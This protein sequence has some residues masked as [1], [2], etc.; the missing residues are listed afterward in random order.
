MLRLLQV[1]VAIR[2][3]R[4]STTGW[5]FGTFIYD[6]RVA[7]NDPYKKLR[8]VGVMWGNDPSLGPN[9][10]QHGARPKQTRLNP[11]TR[12][13]MQHYGWLG[14]LDGPVDNPK[15]SCLSCHSTA[16][17]G[18][19]APMVPPTGTPEG[20]AAWM[21]WFRNIAPPQTFSA[22]TVSLDYSLQMASG[23][24]NLVAWKN[25]CVA[26][27]HAPVIPPCPGGTELLNHAQTPLGYRV[28]R[29]PEQQ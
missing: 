23:L 3:P 18:M 6:G 9:E 11:A 25:A 21:N 12:G 7:G 10:Y 15:S 17:T 28:T 26:D 4:A 13:I 27:P 2:D 5:V 14:R 19:P 16:Q 8:P 20:S 1:D 24:Q 29:S 22:G